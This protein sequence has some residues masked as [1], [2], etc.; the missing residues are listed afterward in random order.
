[1]QKMGV[2]TNDRRIAINNLCLFVSGHFF[3]PCIEPQIP[4]F[5]RKDSML[6]D[7][8]DPSFVM[9]PENLL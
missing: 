6:N 8:N 2:M 5:P 1:M 9:F 3:I 4:L 7:E